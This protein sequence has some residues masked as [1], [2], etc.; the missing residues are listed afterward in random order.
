[1]KV[2]LI[3]SSNLRHLAFI[4][5]LKERKDIAD[6]VLV[7]KKTGDEEFKKC[8]LNHFGAGWSKWIERTRPMFCSS[9]VELHSDEI[10]TRIRTIN[11]DI[12]FVF[13]APLLKKE[14]FSIPKY[15]CINI[16]TGLVEC[17]RGVDSSYWALYDENPSAIGATIHYIDNSIDGGKIIAQRNTEGLSTSDSADDVFMKTCQTGFELLAEN[18]EN[19]MTGQAKTRSL[20]KRG[21]LFQIKDMNDSIMREVRKKTP[22]VLEEYL[23]ENNSRSL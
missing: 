17:Y 12:C 3:T 11:P 21:K 2:L 19:I 7:T 16:H 8:E 6:V 14:L 10:L 20:K 23:N 9:S 1:M 4:N 15:G 22:A 13:G 5:K 18:L